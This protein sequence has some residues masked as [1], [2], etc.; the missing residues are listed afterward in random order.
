LKQIADTNFLITDLFWADKMIP[1]I[2]I[3]STNAQAAPV[4]QNK[5]ST[6][7]L[8][9]LCLPMGLDDVGV[10]RLDEIIGRRRRIARGE[11]LYKLGDPF[12]NIYA[13][14]FGHFKT[15]QLNPT[16]E[17]QTTGFQMAGELLGMEAI[18]AEK[19]NCEAVALEDSEVCEIPFAK[20]ET[21]LG[22]MPMLLRHFHRIMSQEITREQSVM[23]LL[24]N[25]RAEQRF[26]VFLTNLSARYAARGYSSSSFQLRMSREDI[27]NYLSLTIESVSRLLANF[28]KQ[29]WLKVD[30][31]EVELLDPALLKSLAA[32]VDPAEHRSR[33]EDERNHAGYSM[34]RAAPAQY[35]YAAC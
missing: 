20:L 5:C 35:A 18:S 1:T 9:K 15:Y 24:G 3:I 22:Q 23:L 16:G 12:K 8:K 11:S 2:Q 34:T 14:R 10:S 33:L 25:M 28:K 13:I 32:G 6:C 17:Q 19:H 30:K 4:A 21:L 29:G 7:A 31:R 26:A 27:G